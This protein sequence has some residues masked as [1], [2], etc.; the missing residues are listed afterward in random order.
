MHHPDGY[1]VL[2]IIQGEIEDILAKRGICVVHATI[3]RCVIRF[4]SMIEAI[5]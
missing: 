1:S 2:H 4:A 3:K 5:A